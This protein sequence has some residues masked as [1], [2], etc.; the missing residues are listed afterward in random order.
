MCWWEKADLW[1]SGWHYSTSFKT[2]EDFLSKMHSF[3][4]TKLNEERFRDWTRIVDRVRKGLDLW[5]RVGEVYDRREGN[6]DVPRILKA[7][8]AR[9]GYLLNRDASNV[10]FVDYG[11][12]EDTGE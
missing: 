5:D 10:G 8:T 7:E 12:E 1:N 6:A 4:H 3:S 11:S 9:F 2:V